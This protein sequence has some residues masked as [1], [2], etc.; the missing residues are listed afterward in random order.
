MAHRLV[1]LKSKDLSYNMTSFILALGLSMLIGLSV[2]MSTPESPSY[3][4]GVVEYLVNQGM[5]AMTS[6]ELFKLNADKYIEIIT[7][8]EAD[9]VDIIVFP[10][11]CLNGHLTAVIVPTE[12]EDIDLCTNSSY[13]QNLRNIACAAKEEK[14]YVVVN[15]IMKRNCTEVHEME[16]EHHGH[17]DEDEENV[18]PQEWLLYNTNVVFDRN[19]KVISI[20]RKFNLFG[21]RGITQPKTAD[22]STFSTDFGVEFGHFICFDL[23]FEEP[24]LNLVARG[25]KNIIFPTMWFSELPFLSAVQIQQNWAH[26]N[27]VNFLGAGANNVQVG[28]GGSGIYSGKSGALVSIMTG[29][30]TTKLLVHEVP[31]VP[32]SPVTST[33]A[34]YSGSDFDNFR[35]KRDQLDIYSFKDIELSSSTSRLSDSF[36]LCNNERGDEL[37]CDFEIEAVQ[38]SVSENAVSYVYKAAV[39]NGNRTFDG[40]ADGNMTT[41][42]IL[43]CKNDTIASCGIRFFTNE[44]TNGQVESKISFEKIVIHGIF[45]K[46]RVF[47]LPNSLNFNLDP[48]PTTD[49]TY[50]ELTNDRSRNKEIT[51]SLLKPK[52]DLFAFAIYGR[53]FRTSSGIN[54]ISS[55]LTLLLAFI[56]KI[57]VI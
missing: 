17:E 38:Q 37:C 56:L 31:K 44:T 10:E 54:V 3:T 22:I 51:I 46:E 43:A 52:T 50:K 21:E 18:C 27:N 14:K 35:L 11:M 28:S 8:E 40:V 32:G 13:D 7:S 33:S 5:T 20:Y 42:A 26:S 34:A 15:L 12:T 49:F 30:A 1:A 24:A 41:C 48:Y 2:Q 55:I 57:F 25:I 39:F 16:H 36:R 6:A 53:D 45:P 23:M 19:G 4:A 47:T 29:E 9:N